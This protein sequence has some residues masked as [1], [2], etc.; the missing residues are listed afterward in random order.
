MNNLEDPYVSKADSKLLAE[1]TGHTTE[2]VLKW[3]Q[4]KRARYLNFK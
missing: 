2:Q 1:Q 3:L 4:N